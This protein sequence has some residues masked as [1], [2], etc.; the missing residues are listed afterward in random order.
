MKTILMI[1]LAIITIIF[2]IIDFSVI[3]N[4]D[5]QEEIEEII[6]KIIERDEEKK[7]GRSHN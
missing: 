3:I 2:V 4:Y 1:I 5:E 6:S 7:N